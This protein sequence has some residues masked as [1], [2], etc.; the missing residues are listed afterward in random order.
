MKKFQLIKNV[1]SKYIVKT[2]CSISIF[3]FVVTLR[4]LKSEENKADSSNVKQSLG[5]ILP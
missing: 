3:Y 1:L 5:G 4:N 2:A